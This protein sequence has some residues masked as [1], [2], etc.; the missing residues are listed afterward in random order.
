MNKTDFLL[1]AKL[2]QQFKY[3]EMLKIALLL[4]Q[5]VELNLAT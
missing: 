3:K 1:C 2:S 4:E 5:E